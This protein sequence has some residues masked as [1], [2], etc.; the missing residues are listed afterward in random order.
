M[1]DFKQTV[2]EIVDQEPIKSFDLKL[3]G[4]GGDQV[5]FETPGSVKKIIKV[6]RNFVGEKLVSLLKKEFYNKTEDG[7]LDKLQRQEIAKHKEIEKGITEVFGAE[8]VL[9][10]G[11]FKVKIPFTKATIAKFFEED[12]FVNRQ[13]KT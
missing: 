3:I 1:E 5:V 6:S 11:V 10:H 2:H 12:D 4:I 7:K 9:K 13:L 8:H